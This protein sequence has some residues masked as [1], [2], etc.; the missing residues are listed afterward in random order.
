[1]EGE[2]AGLMSETATV[3]PMG[4]YAPQEKKIEKPVSNETPR[5][6]PI[7]GTGQKSTEE[8][9]KTENIEA[10]LQKKDDPEAQ[11]AATV[12]LSRDMNIYQEKQVEWLAKLD[13]DVVAKTLDLDTLTVK[14]IS[15]KRSSYINT[16]NEFYSEKRKYQVLEM[17]DDAPLSYEE[18][19][20]TKKR[21]LAENP[22]NEESLTSINKFLKTKEDLT[23]S[24]SK[25]NELELVLGAEFRKMMLPIREAVLGSSELT[26][27][28]KIDTVL[29]I[30]AHLPGPVLADEDNLLRRYYPVASEQ[31]K[32]QISYVVNKN[33]GRDLNA[34]DVIPLTDL[35]G[36]KKDEYFVG[37]L[38]NEET[39]GDFIEKR[40]APAFFPDKD[41]KLVRNSWEVLKKVTKYGDLEGTSFGVSYGNVDT[42]SMNIS[43]FEKFMENY[44][45]L[46]PLVEML[47]DYG[48]DYRPI[49]F[50]EKNFDEEYIDKLKILGKDTATLKA[51]L[52]SIKKIDPS[53][54]YKYCIKSRYCDDT[55]KVEVFI[56]DNPFTIALERNTPRDYNEKA[57]L[58]KFITLFESF[59]K[60]VPERWRGEF[61]STYIDFLST[62]SG[63][64]QGTDVSKIAIAEASK[65]VFDPNIT[66]EQL[67]VFATSFLRESLKPGNE[68]AKVAFEFCDKYG[69]KIATNID[70]KGR[71]DK[72]ATLF[73]FSFW[74]SD[75]YRYQILPENEDIAIGKAKADLTLAKDA[76]TKITDF[77]L[78][79]KA[80]ANLMYAL[81]DEDV[82][83]INSAELYMGMMKD[84]SLRQNC[85]KLIDLEKE[86]ARL[87]ETTTWKKMEKIREESSNN[88][89]FLKEVFGFGTA[90]GQSETRAKYSQI[91]A[92]HYSDN[93]IYKEFNPEDP[94]RF[95]KETQR[96]KDN[97]QVSVNMTWKNVLQTLESGEIISYW[98]NPETVQYRKV[99]SK[100]N[101]EERRDQIERLVGNRAKGGIRDPQPIY[102]AAATP[103]GRDEFYGG[104]GGG[105]GECFIVLKN[106]KIKDRTS[107]SYDDSFDGFN[108]WLLG[109]NDALTAK[110]IHNLNGSKSTHGY[111]EAQILGG[112]TL[113]D[114]ESINIPSD[115]ISG[116]N[117]YGFSAESDV[118][119]QINDL[120]LRYPDIKINIVNISK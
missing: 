66:P 87:G 109:W 77:E 2:S 26:E 3:E 65:Y 110:S 10:L 35:F 117:K 104:T 52:D 75:L 106:D 6:I 67:G 81:T 49:D 48:F 18:L 76:V 25:Q 63:V 14:E 59:E 108:K 60:I 84:E 99:H 90:E 1:M 68:N 89:S 17:D 72:D 39:T 53:Y 101:Y 61:I 91:M 51:E 32:R 70:G 69:D 94:A 115:A 111:V 107:F 93:S 95:N 114:V 15:D 100:Y 44:N 85:Q 105:Y 78:K 118:L 40:V 46:A 8:L 96:I 58:N 31:L 20:K 38:G 112:V 19:E 21:I 119:S 34:F 113:N 82:G 86:R 74:V 71:T 102:G 27:K 116:E 13:L 92:G 45:D 103:N 88:A 33:M 36:E 79:D 80:I 9:I 4:M 57:D 7:E 12:L 23:A 83:D 56:K 29:G 54:E 43:V 50:I 37:I 120:R 16:A 28:Y 64:N 22:V 30:C 62:T 42:Q 98:E 55:S 11:L 47:S 97:F 5:N 73:T 24:Y 41:P